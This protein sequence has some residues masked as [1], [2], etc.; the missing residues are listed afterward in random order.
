MYKA[1]TTALINQFPES[2]KPALM[3]GEGSPPHGR[4]L[5]GDGVLQDARQHPRPPP[6]DATALLCQS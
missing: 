5:F 2:G 3:L 4:W 1:V 6:Q